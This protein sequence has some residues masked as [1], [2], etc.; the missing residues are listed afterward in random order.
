FLN[1][2]THAYMSLSDSKVPDSQAGFEAGMGALLA[3]L[4]G[5]NMISG[6]GMLDFESTQSVEKLIVDNEIIGMVKRFVQGIE[7]YGSPFATEI[8]K[9]YEETQ[10][11]LSHPTTLKY[12]RKELFLPSSI[13]DRNTRDTWKALGSKS[14]RKRAREEASKLESKAPINPIDDTLIN[15]LDKIAKNA[16]K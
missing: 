10:E 11:L 2:P 7:D 8:L 9:D 5:N 13:I 16:L 6:P 12:F 1:M 14:T 4:A 15:E 3:A